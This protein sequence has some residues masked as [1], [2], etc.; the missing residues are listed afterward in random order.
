[1]GRDCVYVR[2]DNKVDGQTCCH[3]QNCFPL[4]ATT[5]TH[6][7]RTSRKTTGLFYTLTTSNAL[8]QNLGIQLRSHTPV[9]VIH[10][11]ILLDN[12]FFAGSHCINP[13]TPPSEHNLE[14]YGW[15]STHP[16]AYQLQA[17]DIGPIAN[18]TK[19]TYRCKQD[20]IYNR[21][22]DDFSKN[23]YQLDC[24][25]ENTFSTPSWPNCKSSEACLILDVC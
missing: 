21:F 4:S 9:N 5:V 22:E 10:L 1:M 3:R 7:A 23:K 15:K 16:P 14:L 11:S 18:N 6:L 17:S 8:R 13:P 24:L 2:H 20:G 12:S 25:A 19:V